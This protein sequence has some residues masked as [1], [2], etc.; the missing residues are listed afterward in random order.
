MSAKSFLLILVSAATAT[1]SMALFRTILKDSYRW[2]GSLPEFLHDTL[3][4]FG[5]PVFLL[6]CLVF[7]TSTVLW[8]I[9][10][11]TQKL[12]LAYPVQIGLVVIFTGV[13]SAFVFSESISVRGYLGYLLLILGVFLV[14]R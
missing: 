14:S 5:K 4:L 13:V 9:V 11:A 7:V 2:K 1:T 8:L 10:L 6:A 12:S 3:A